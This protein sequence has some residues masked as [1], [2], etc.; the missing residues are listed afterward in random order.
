MENKKGESQNK[1]PSLQISKY[2]SHDIK[3]EINTAGLQLRSK[4]DSILTNSNQSS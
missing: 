3:R 4:P 2:K 1:L